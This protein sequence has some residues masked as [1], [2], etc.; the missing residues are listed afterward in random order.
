MW[1]YDPQLMGPWGADDAMEYW[2]DMGINETMVRGRWQWVT[3]HWARPL[4]TCVTAAQRAIPVRP[5]PRAEH[6]T[7]P[8]LWVFHVFQGLRDPARLGCAAE[9]KEGYS[10]Y[11]YGGTCASCPH[12]AADDL[13]RQSL[14][15]K[16]MLRAAAP[17]VQSDM[18]PAIMTCGSSQ[19]IR[20][21]VD[22]IAPLGFRML[23]TQVRVGS[24]VSDRYC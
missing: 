8:V 2:Y 18:A 10:R 11:R 15:R 3:E 24:G 20:S 19:C 4:F 16:K 6:V 9:A 5:G 13:D 12:A 7:A 21:S 17:Q 14:S 22:T 1:W 23:H